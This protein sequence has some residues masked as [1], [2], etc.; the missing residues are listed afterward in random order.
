MPVHRVLF[1][2]SRNR[3]RSLTA[4]QVFRAWPNVETNNM[5]TDRPASPTTR[6]RCCR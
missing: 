2:C 1:L 5:E 3:L 4:E 6:T